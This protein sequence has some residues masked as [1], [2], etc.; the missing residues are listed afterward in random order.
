MNKP[1]SQ[2]SDP[3]SVL[4]TWANDSDEWVRYLVKGVLATGRALGVDEINHGYQLFRQEKLLDERVIAAEPQLETATTPQEVEESFRLTRISEVVGVNALAPGAVIEPHAGLTIL[5]GE[6]GTGKTGYARILKALANSRTADVILGDIGLETEEPQ[7]AKVEYELGSSPSEYR[8]GGERGQSPFNR[9]SIFDSPSVNFHVDDDLEYVYTPSSLALFNHV[10]AALRGVQER[11]D[12]TATELRSRTV[13]LLSRFSRDSSLYPLIEQLGAA[14]DLDELRKHADTAA[15]ADERIEQ[16]QRAVAALEANTIANQITISQRLERVLKQAVQGCEVASNFDSA[17]YG[18]FL[19]SRASLAK[20]YEVF[21]TELFAAAGLAAEPEETWTTFVR[22]GEAYRQHLEQQGAHDESVCLYCRQ[23][24]NSDA[25]A[26]ILK[27]REFLEGKIAGEIAK[28]ETQLTQLLAQPKALALGDLS[29][30]LDENSAV[31]PPPSDLVLLRKASGLVT[32]LKAQT[33]EYAAVRPELGTDAAA[34]AVSLKDRLNEI[35]ASLVSL[36][37]QAANRSE[38]LKKEGEKL[39]EL[40]AAVELGKSWQQVESQVSDAKEADRLAILAKTFPVVSRQVTELSKAASDRMINESFDTLFAEEC[41]ALRAPPLK[42]QFLGR[43]GK[44][45][46]RKVLQGKHK[47]SKVLSEGEQKVLAIADFLAEAR[48][49]GITAT[50]VFDDPVTSLDHRRIDEVANRVAKL[51]ESTQ[52]IVFTH[53]ILFAVKLLSL[54]ETSKRCT[55]YEVS[56]YPNTGHIAARSGPRWDTINTLK[57]RIE[58]AISDAKAAEGEAQ[59]A[60]VSAGYGSLRSWC[61]VFTETELFQGV[62]QR[63]QPNVRMTSLPNIKVGALPAA[64]AT[65][66]D[67]FDRACRYI[68]GH[69]Q[70]LP[71]RGVSPTPQN[72]EDDWKLLQACRKE[73]LDA[74]A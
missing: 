36:Q 16:Q 5:F 24:L 59:D 44:A 18:R 47:P 13:G 4:V 73:W 14:T 45:H 23:P 9:M 2:G 39:I 72:L 10:N 31:D 51:A 8:W 30:Y 12:E 15:N 53:D 22:S 21:R 64:I 55:Y 19:E 28:C 3:R 41:A 25:A 58:E 71:T 57:K 27:Y 46:R 67:V 50:V 52:I 56:D 35:T 70:P 69:S 7:S 38:A 42:V 74:A 29:A 62:T 60:L 33:T 43:Q 37:E 20:D 66:T 17:E 34:C 26:L 54:F 6:N 63:Y 11:A 68:D 32:E 1:D 48:L 61:E 65:V 49:S 40:K